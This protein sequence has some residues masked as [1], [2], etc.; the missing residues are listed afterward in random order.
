MLRAVLWTLSLWL[1]VGAG[2]PAGAGGAK[3]WSASTG[4][5]LALGTLRGTAV[6]ED[7]RVALAPPLET[8]WGPAEGIVWAVAPAGG[9]GAFVALS[10]P[11]RVVRV[12]RGSPAI[13]LSSSVVQY[14][15]E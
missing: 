13:T 15:V 1:C 2:S 11:G 5:E 6:D 7:G 14:N 12:Q 9:D 8:L 3:S 4:D 10:G